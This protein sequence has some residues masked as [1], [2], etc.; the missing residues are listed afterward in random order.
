MGIDPVGSQMP[1]RKI[2]IDGIT[3]TQGAYRGIGTKPK[4]QLSILLNQALF[5]DYPGFD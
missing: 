1:E 3:P 5:T 2:Q 4:V